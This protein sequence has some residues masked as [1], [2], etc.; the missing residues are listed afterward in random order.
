M[1][2]LYD[3]QIFSLVTH[4]GIPRYHYELIKSLNEIGVETELPLFFSNNYYLKNKDVSN[5]FS[6]LPFN[7]KV[8]NR[9]LPKF[10]RYCSKR[11]LMKRDYDVF[12][13]TFCS[14]YFLDYLKGKPFVFTVHHLNTFAPDRLFVPG[15]EELI[16]KANHII[17]ISEATKND[18]LNYTS[19]DEHKITVIHHGCSLSPSLYPTSGKN[20]WEKPYILYVGGRQPTK[21]FPFLLK[22]FKVI[23]AKYDLMLLCTGS[24]FSSSEKKMIAGMGLSD[25]VKGFIVKNDAEMCR[26][27]SDAVC[28][29]YPSLKEGFGMPILEAFA[30]K[31]PVLVSNASCLPEIAGDAGL[32]FDPYDLDSLI[33]RL[34]QIL[35]SN[36]MRNEL[37]HKGIKRS[38]GGYFRGEKRQKKL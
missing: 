12:H 9:T 31:C 27:Y 15:E 7:L 13:P 37:I 34:S 11:A 35:S 32:Y 2:I 18:M 10:N 17:A 22:A 6:S 33:D 30:C 38:G 14:H 16:K 25:R 21:N 3:D 24:P 26:L 23:S 36:D 20:K 28:F 1:K 4:S 8:F 29:V 5:H 19:I